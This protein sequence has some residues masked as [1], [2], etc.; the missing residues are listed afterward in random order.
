MNFVVLINQNN[1][2]VFRENENDYHE[3]KNKL[4]RIWKFSH[5]P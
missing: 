2:K 4:L 3:K 1:V 5:T